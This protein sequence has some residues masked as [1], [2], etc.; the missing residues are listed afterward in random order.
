MILLFIILLNVSIIAIIALARGCHNL[1]VVYLRRCL[2]VD[3][4]A[5]IAL[6]QCCPQL[7]EL[8]IGGC[9]QITDQSLQA[10]GQHCKHLSSVNFA[11]ANVSS[12]SIQF[13]STIFLF[14]KT[15]SGEAL[16]KIL[17][18]SWVLACWESKGKV[19]YLPSVHVT[20][21]SSKLVLN[22]VEYLTL[23]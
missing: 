3:D 14:L 15:T 4:D 18:D 11:R 12:Y 22:L 17:I 21:F 7:R 20:G 19:T 6:A 2:C 16:E 9:S 8:N 1:W 10:L 23:L 5:I 13:N